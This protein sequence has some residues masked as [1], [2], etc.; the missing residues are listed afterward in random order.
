MKGSYNL[1]ISTN[2]D[3]RMYAFLKM[4]SQM[5]ITSAI[6]PQI[7]RLRSHSA[8]MRKA[9]MQNAYAKADAYAKHPDIRLKTASYATKRWSHLQILGRICGLK[10]QK[11][12][13]IHKSD[14][15][16]VL[17]A[18]I[19]SEFLQMRPFYCRT[20]IH[21]FFAYVISFQPQYAEYSHMMRPHLFL[22]ALYKGA[23][24]ANS[25]YGNFMDRVNFKG[26]ND[27]G[28]SYKV[29]IKNC[30]FSRRF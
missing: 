14:Y 28:I 1:Q 16:M 5:R 21:F 7:C 4:W 26:R 2:L 12:R 6:F 18:Y 15:E 3:G 27:V 19:V 24:V 11:M 23:T 22:V 30:V 25:D 8:H 17:Y 10:Q 13:N 20:C 9:L 29:F